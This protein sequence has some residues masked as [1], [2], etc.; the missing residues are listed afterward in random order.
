M[1]QKRFYTEDETLDMVLG[2]K[3]TPD[4]DLYEAE[5]DALIMGN[6]IRKARLARNVTQEQLGEMTGMS[7]TQVSRIENGRST[8]L[9]GISRVLRPLGISASLEMAGV[10][11]FEL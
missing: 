10:G 2:E 7:R 4:R 6:A 8:S 5:M 3:G 11:R 9:S 1:K